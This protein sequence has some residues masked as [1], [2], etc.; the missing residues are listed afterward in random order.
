MKVMVTIN[1]S[2]DADITNWMRGIIT[3]IVLDH[4]EHQD[5]FEVVKGEVTL[6]YPPAMIIFKPLKTSCPNLTVSNKAKFPYSQLRLVS[7]SQHLLAREYKD[8]FCFDTTRIS[9]GVLCSQTTSRSLPPLTVPFIIHQTTNTALFFSS[10]LP[11]PSIFMLRCLT[12]RAMDKSKWK[13]T[14][15]ILPRPQQQPPLLE[16]SSH[17]DK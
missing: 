9:H 7:T 8:T 15:P 3:D 10:P 5:G 16:L 6:L 2:T 13:C 17:M 1:I 4:R 11:H 14:V 12:T